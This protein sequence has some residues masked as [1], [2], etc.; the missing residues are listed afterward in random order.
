MNGNDLQWKSEFVENSCFRMDESIRMIRKSF[1][2]L[3]DSDIWKRPNPSSNSI[4]NLVLHLRGNITQYVI[5]S[6]GGTPD[7]RQRE[8]E[9]RINPGYSKVELLKLLTDTLEQAK[10]TMI[11]CEAKELLRVRHV[12]GFRFSGI[13]IVIHAVEHLSYHTGQI[14]FWT[15]IL[16]DEDLGFYDGTDLNITN[17]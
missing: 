16:K 3:T 6:L 1:D 11:R 2:L 13:G 12:Q 10:A 15:K 7:I 14:A 9:F 17:G 4:G 8:R 5:S